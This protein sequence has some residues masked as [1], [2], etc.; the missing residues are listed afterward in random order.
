MAWH[1]GATRLA[2]RPESDGQADIRPT[3]FIV[4]SLTAPWAAKRTFKH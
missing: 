2:R 3:Q 1:P 4:H